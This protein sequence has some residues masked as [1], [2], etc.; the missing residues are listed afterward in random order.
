MNTPGTSQGP[1]GPQTTHPRNQPAL[2]K[3]VP[4]QPAEQF[5]F[6]SP[7]VEEIETEFISRH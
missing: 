4:S 5:N 7:E 2:I 3:W 6:E 1:Q